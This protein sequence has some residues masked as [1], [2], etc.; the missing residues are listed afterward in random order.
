MGRLQ[1]IKVKQ[2]VN[3]VSVHIRVNPDFA[4]LRALVTPPKLV[5]LILTKRNKIVHAA[6]MNELFWWGFAK[7]ALSFLILT[8][9]VLHVVLLFTLIFHMLKQCVHFLTIN[10]FKL[11]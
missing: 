8:V 1:T 7:L 4:A 11:L 5:S 3:P 6:L 10:I 2:N 9:V